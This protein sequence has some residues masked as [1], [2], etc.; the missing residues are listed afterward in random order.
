MPA[1][2]FLF[3][4]LLAAVLGIAADPVID[5][6][7]FPELARRIRHF[8]ERITCPDESVRK[9]VLTELIYFNQRDS[10][11]YPPLLVCLLADPSP[12]IRW[13]ALSLL[14]EHGIQV[15]ERELHDSISVP[16]IGL[17]DRTKPDSV[18]SFRRIAEGEEASAG[19]AIKAL[20]L[21]GDK[22]S[23]PQAAKQLKSDNVF[24]RYSAAVMLI[25]L[26]EAPPG[27]DALCGIA[28]DVTDKSAYYR[29]AA[30][31]RLCRMGKW[32]YLETIIDTIHTRSGYADNSL[33]ILEDLTGVYFP[34]E[35]EW[36]QWWQTEGRKKYA[37][38]S[39]L[40]A[41]WQSALQ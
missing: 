36:R 10:K 32:Q 4:T 8:D 31:E 19:W 39:T 1:R 11:L 16:I 38:D 27:I 2:V 28:A 6:Q 33:T 12:E 29:C 17:L 18:A 7:H 21:I 41:D 34:T 5:S 35:N 13:S 37:A 20:G 22:E 3:A 23:L 9:K 26:G 30:A 14:D 40:R 25:Q 24:I 15:S